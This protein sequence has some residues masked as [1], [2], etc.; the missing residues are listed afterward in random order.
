MASDRIAEAIEVA[1][2][3]DRYGECEP[4]DGLD[5]CKD[6]LKL[7]ADAVRAAQ[8]EREVE[9]MALA[10]YAR[11]Y[12]NLAAAKWWRD[13]SAEQKSQWIDLIRARALRDAFDKGE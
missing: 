5:G 3:C 9:L 7:A 2:R 13:F 11:D 12:N 1:E 4:C 8:S 10:M 6:C